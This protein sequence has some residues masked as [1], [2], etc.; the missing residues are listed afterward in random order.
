MEKRDTLSCSF[1]GKT[2]K[3]AKH[4]IAG[5]SDYICDECVWLCSDIL[6]KETAE[7]SRTPSRSA[8][9]A[10]QTDARRPACSFCHRSQQEVRKLV[11]GTGVCVNICHECLVAAAESVAGGSR[12][13]LERIL[14]LVQR[15]DANGVAVVARH[16]A[17]A[18]D[19]AGDLPRPMAERARAL[20]E[21][22]AAL[23]RE[24]RPP[25]RE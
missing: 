4:L 9:E 17:K 24:A 18:C 21:E 2:Q 23:A 3:E 11:V 14:W 16:F 12:A 7:E 25:E 8:T 22:I 13:D 15:P 10:P 19:E 1:C 6:A 20:A 5:G